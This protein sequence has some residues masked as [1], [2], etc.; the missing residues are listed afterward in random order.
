MRKVR[1][2]KTALNRGKKQRVTVDESVELSSRAIKQRMS[3][4][5]P[6]LRRRPGEYLPKP[7]SISSSSSSGSGSN[8]VYAS[9]SMSTLAVRGAA[10]VPVPPSARGE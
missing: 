9:S 10:P 3:D 7:I 6:I 1:A 8:S 4:M 5:A 2:K